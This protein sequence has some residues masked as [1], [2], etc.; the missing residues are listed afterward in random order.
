MTTTREFNWANEVKRAEG[1]EF[2]EKPVAYEF[3][4]GRK[5]KEEDPHGPYAWTPEQLAEFA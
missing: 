4:T 3:S 2:F 5:F 1:E